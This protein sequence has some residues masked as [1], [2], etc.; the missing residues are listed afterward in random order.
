M[1]VTHVR[2]MYS[3]VAQ[4]ATAGRLDDYAATPNPLVAEEDADDNE[5]DGSEVGEEARGFNCG[6]CERRVTS[7]DHGFGCDEQQCRW[8]LCVTCYPP[9]ARRGRL[10]CPEHTYEWG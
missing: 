10:L 4:S 2:G 6:R 1:R 3:V 7:R 8:G 9:R 5:S